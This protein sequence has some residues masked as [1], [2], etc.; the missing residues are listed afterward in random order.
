ML[1]PGYSDHHGRA[2]FLS[3]RPRTSG[4]TCP[5]RLTPHRFHQWVNKKRDREAE[6]TFPT[7]Y[8]ANTPGDIRRLAKATGLAVERVERVEGRPEYLRVTAPTYLAGWH[9]ERRVN[10]VPVL[11]PFRILLIAVLRKPQAL[12]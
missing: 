11:A 4:T 8:R 12:G 3:P 6:D 5:A 2:V 1:R 10:V 7:R 9:Y